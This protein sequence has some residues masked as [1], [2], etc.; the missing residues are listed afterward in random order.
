[1]K[2]DKRKILIGLGASLGTA[3]GFVRIC[4]KPKDIEKF[5][6]DDILV[7]E[8]TDPTWTIYMRKA[9]AIITSIGGILCHAAI[10]A[11]EF[12]IPCVVGVK[13]ATKILKDGMKIEVDGLKGTI[14]QIEE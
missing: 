5:N 8:T 9:K 13:D 14:Y 2:K 12:G 7:T 4:H 10:V 1:M 6:S 11:R 3:V